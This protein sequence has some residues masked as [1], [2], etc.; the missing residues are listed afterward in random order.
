MAERGHQG[1]V[2]PGQEVRVFAP[3]GIGGRQ[4]LG[5]VIC[6]GGRRALG[7]VDQRGLQFVRNH[8]QLVAAHVQ[9]RIDSRLDAD[10]DMAWR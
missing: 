2:M 4:V 1:G 7:I 6:R 3:V 5:V 10:L 9:Q 8:A